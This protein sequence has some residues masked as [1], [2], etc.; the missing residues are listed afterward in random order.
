MLMSTGD[1]MDP[2]QTGT[3]DCKGQIDAALMLYATVTA[4]LQ[5]ICVSYVGEHLLFEKHLSLVK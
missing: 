4:I 2:E 5:G 1:Q 3:I